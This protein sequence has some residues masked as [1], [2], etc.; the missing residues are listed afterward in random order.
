MLAR[1]GP[2][3]QAGLA[4]SGRLVTL[5]AI[6]RERTWSFGIGREAL[7]IQLDG[8]AI[9]AR[10]SA[11]RGLRYAIDRILIEHGDPMCTQVANCHGPDHGALSALEM[12]TS[13]SRPSSPACV[14]VPAPAHLS[15]QTHRKAPIMKPAPNRLSE[16]PCRWHLPSSSCSTAIA[17]RRQGD[18][19]ERRRCRQTPVPPGRAPNRCH[20]RLRFRRE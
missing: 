18:L 8:N 9:L 3:G 17:A 16:L 1:A 19:P 14:L 5:S 6:A 11:S 10:D 20:G 7:L 4:T 2:G 12:R 13:R 15:V